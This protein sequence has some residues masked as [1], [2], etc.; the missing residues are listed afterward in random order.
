[1]DYWKKHLQFI[2][3]LLRRCLLEIL[4][5]FLIDCLKRRSD[6]DDVLKLVYKSA[7]PYA[8]Q[9]ALADLACKLTTKNVLVV[10]LAWSELH[11]S[12]ALPVHREGR[13]VNRGG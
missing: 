4:R 9:N 1:M 12:I 5:P 7:S 13:Q 8:T 11:G 2:S 3:V 10:L 6:F